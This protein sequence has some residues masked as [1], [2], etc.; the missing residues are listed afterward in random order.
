MAELAASTQI[1]GG[2]MLTETHFDAIRRSGFRNVEVFAAPGHF[3]W[4]DMAYVRRSAAALRACGLTVCSLHAPWAPG[5]D[6]AAL[7]STEREASLAAVEQ[8]ADALLVLEGHLLVLHPGATANDPARREQQLVYARQGIA[9]LAGYCAARRLRIALENPPPYEL[10]GDNQCML[11]LY[12]SFAREPAVQACF[13][14]GHAHI[15]PEG[16]GVVC[17]VP[18]DLL[19]VHLSDNTGQADDHMLPTRGTVNWDD[20]FGLLRERRFGGYLVLELV[21][22]PDPDTILAMGRTWM[23]RYQSFLPDGS[24]E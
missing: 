1:Y 7:D 13:D 11:A 4:Q 12:D 21:D 19:L 16:V 8:A 24:V 2:Q 6:I 10:G 22:C 5:Q 14:T 17:R 15:S 23:E 9:R 3:D 18:K 20:F